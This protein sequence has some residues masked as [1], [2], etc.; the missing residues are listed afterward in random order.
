TPKEVRDH[1][2]KLIKLL[3]QDGG[4]IMDA[5]AIIQNDAKVE[6]IQAM[7]E[8]TR[9]YG[10]YNVPAWSGIDKILDSEID[11]STHDVIHRQKPS[12]LT[13]YPPAGVC[14]PWQEKRKEIPQ[15]K[16]DELLVEQIWN[17][18]EAHGYTFIWQMLLSF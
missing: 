8:A 1:C 4:Y 11:N 5:S 13:G 18:I 15:I 17:G 9:E 7:T 6:N 12:W 16:G 3:A 10:I 2:K 14:L